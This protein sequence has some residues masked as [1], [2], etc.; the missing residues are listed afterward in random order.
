MAPLAEEKVFLADLLDQRRI[1]EFLDTSGPVRQI[2]R[3]L[4]DNGVSGAVFGTKGGLSRRETKIL[5]MIC[6]GAANKFIANALGLSEATVKFHLGNIY[7]KLGCKKRQE[8]ISAARAL[9]FVT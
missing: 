2:M 8:A 6:E 1:G 3:R 7:R 5:L 4:R 9:G